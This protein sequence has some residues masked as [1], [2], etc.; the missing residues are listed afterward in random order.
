MRQTFGYSTQQIV[1]EF[2][3]AENGAFVVVFAEFGKRFDYLRAFTASQETFIGPA[4]HVEQTFTFGFFKKN[5]S[6][7]RCFAI[8]SNYGAHVISPDKI[9]WLKPVTTDWFAVATILKQIVAPVGINV[10]RGSGVVEREQHIA[11]INFDFP[12]NGD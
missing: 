4:Q 7:Y 6:V 2:R 11:N 12:F 8:N 1:C 3:R 9:V 5:F 10:Y